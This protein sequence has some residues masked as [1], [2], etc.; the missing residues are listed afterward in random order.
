MVSIVYINWNTSKWLEAS[1]KALEQSL[2]KV[3]YEIIIID[4]GSNVEDRFAEW[5]KLRP[6]YRYI[7]NPENMGFG[8]ACNQ[9]IL[10]SRGRYICFINTDTVPEVGWL[11]CLVEYLEE[12][13]ECGLV[14][15]SMTNVC[16]PMQAREVNK[17]ANVSVRST[18]PFACV[19]I[20]KVMFASYGLLAMFWGEDVEFCQRLLTKGKTIVI[21]GGA[22]VFH[23]G[24][25]A[26]KENK[27]GYSVSAVTEYLKKTVYTRLLGE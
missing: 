9:G 27:L 11:D 7:F 13:P 17:G 23:H 3:K 26:I 21:V 15:P 18:V 5:S 14:A 4:N 8:F 10:A 1:I 20:P 16:Q 25:K 12:H 22:Y 2:P 24:G 6:Q 19:M